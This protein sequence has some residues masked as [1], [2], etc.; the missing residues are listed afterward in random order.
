LRH[1]NVEVVGRVTDLGE[2][3]RSVD[4]VI[5]PM[6]FGT[7]LKIKVAEALAAGAPLLATAHATEGYPTTEPLHLLPDFQAMALELVK[8]AFDPK[9]LPALACRSRAIHADIRPKVLA[10]LEETRC[11]LMA[12]R[13]NSMCIV[14]PIAALDE[15]TLLHDHLASAIDYLR[16][17]VSLRLY[18]VGPAV[19]ADPKAHLRFGHQIKVFASPGLVAELGAGMPEDWTPMRFG[20]LL[21]TWQIRQAYF[22]CDDE[23]EIHPGTE[24]RPGAE[25]LS[26]A[27][28]RYDAVELS[29]G[30]PG[31]LIDRLRR[32]AWVT[33]MSSTIGRAMIWRSQHRIEGVVQVGFRRLGPFHSLPGDGDRSRQLGLVIMG[34]RTDPLAAQTLAL[35]AS[36]GCAGIII[37]PDDPDMV[38]APA[39]GPEAELTSPSVTEAR[40]VVDLTVDNS[41]SAILDEAGQC[42]GIP[43]IRLRRGLAAAV[44]HSGA[45]PLF[46]TSIG[47]LLRTVARGLLDPG[48]LEMLRDLS[49]QDLSSRNTADAGWIWLGDRL[50]GASGTAWTL[51]A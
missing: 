18:V 14:L 11:R 35:G 51:L 10:A 23:G 47:R 48:Y 22:L 6:D 4:V 42:V 9:E 13:Q 26:R 34:K 20:S 37:D 41:V 21:E 17:I 19:N 49:Q 27:F 32:R 39:Y 16:S 45:S 25:H 8:L 15:R 29:G 44:L 33:V 7:G 24:I 40:L 38:R 50:S 30:H 12:Y 43:V 3:Y 36:L 1:P 5:A 2:F 46:P 28:V 31:R